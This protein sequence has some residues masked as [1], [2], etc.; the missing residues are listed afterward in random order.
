MMVDQSL[1]KMRSAFPLSQSGESH[2]RALHWKGKQADRRL[3]SDLNGKKRE[4]NVTEGN[5]NDFKP[6][7][8]SPSCGT[9]V[10]DLKVL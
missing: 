4:V 7:T 10:K 8:V 6:Y 9:C 1:R 5:R 2:L 3:H